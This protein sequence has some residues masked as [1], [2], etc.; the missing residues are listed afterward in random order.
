MIT[1]II[2]NWHILLNRCKFYYEN[3]KYFSVFHICKYCWRKY[4]L[5]RF[6]ITQYNL[7]QASSYKAHQIDDGWLCNCARG[8]TKRMFYCEYIKISLFLL[9]FFTPISQ[10][11]KGTY[12][13]WLVIGLGRVYVTRDSAT[14]SW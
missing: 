6:Y 10:Y 14:S 2:S 1:I 5:H 3:V 8:Y 9:K 12:L 11:R 13:I 4:H 7:P